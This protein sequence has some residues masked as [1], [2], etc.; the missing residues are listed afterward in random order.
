MTGFYLQ[1]SVTACVQTAVFLLTRRSGSSIRRTGPLK[2]SERSGWDEPLY[3][4]LEIFDAQGRYINMH[5]M[6]GSGLRSISLTYWD[7]DLTPGLPV[8]H[9]LHHAKPLQLPAGQEPLAELSS[10]LHRL[11]GQN[12]E[13][14]KRVFLEIPEQSF[15]VQNAIA[16]IHSILKE[17]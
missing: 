6:K 10:G 2:R 9:W 16:A 1:K 14:A 12:I 5:Y 3:G 7:I 17:D 13:T 15:S 8:I 11:A 4:V